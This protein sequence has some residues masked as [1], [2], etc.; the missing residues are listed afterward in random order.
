MD[1]LVGLHSALTRARLD[2]RS[3][4]TASER[5]TLDAAL[6]GY[7]ADGAW[8][9]HVEDSL[10]GVRV[11]ARADLVTW[12]SNLYDLEPDPARLLTERAA[13]TIV[14]GDIVHDATDAA[15]PAG[16]TARRHAPLLGERHCVIVPQT[17]ENIRSLSGPP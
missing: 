12:S 6:R 15:P 17:R 2:G 1:P 11:G 13:L 5:L 16:G 10:G 7:T 9:W 14:A 8:A 4:W 3:S